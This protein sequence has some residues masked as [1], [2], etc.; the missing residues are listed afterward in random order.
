MGPF[1]WLKG[2]EN[3]IAFFIQHFPYLIAGAW[4]TVKLTVFSVTIGVVLGT[5]FGIMKTSKVRLFS[6]I[7]GVYTDFIRGTPLLVQIFIVHFGMPRVLGFP[8]NP[9]VSAVT[10]LSINS[11]AYVTEIV[12][13]GIQSIDRGQIE[14]ARSLGMNNFL[15]MRY[16]ILPQAFKRIIPPLGN[17]FIAMLKDSS[18]VSVIAM[19]ELVRKGQI[20]STTY[21]KP[22]ETWTAI[23]FIFLFLTLPITRL[24]SYLEGV[25]AKGDQNSRLA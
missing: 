19:E 9:Y 23:A 20:L 11:G 6:M 13:A 5:I 1:G 12:R 4:V 25:M 8:L 17:E 3:Y 18:L 7:S 21:F 15:A 16:V 22:F 24:V 10:A 2:I 14:A